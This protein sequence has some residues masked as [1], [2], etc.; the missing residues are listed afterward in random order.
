MP[1]RAR[2]HVADK[3]FVS[4]HVYQSE[5][6]TRFFQECKAQSNRDSAALLFRKT[7]RVGAGQRFD[8]RGFP[9]IDVPGRA[10]NDAL[11]RSGPIR[12][13]GNSSAALDATGGENRGSNLGTYFAAAISSTI[14]C[15]AA[16]G[17]AAARMG[18]PTT[19]K[20]APA[21]IASVGVAFRAWSSELDST[22]ESF[23]RTPGVTIT[24]SGP[25][26]LRIALASCTEATTP[27]TPAR[28]A[29]CA[30][31]TTPTLGAPPIPTSFMVF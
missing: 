5:P 9:V 19:R 4:R 12:M 22:G 2:Q 17:S 11:H 14:A 23:E 24:K 3:S 31:F 30:N 27:S 13:R 28:F 15:A 6:H 7:I 16:R 1:R 20:S 10:N 29:S 25:P 18:L 26:A 21:R 8:Q